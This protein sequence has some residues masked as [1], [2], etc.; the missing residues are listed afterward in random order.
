M[1][2]GSA[3][4]AHS[5]ASLPLL[6]R[7]TGLFRQLRFRREQIARLR[8]GRPPEC[9]R[10]ASPLLDLG[11]TLPHRP[12][13]QP[14]RNDPARAASQIFSDPRSQ[15]NNT[16][17]E[18]LN[19]Q[20]EGQGEGV[21]WINPG[22]V[23]RF[24]HCTQRPF[25]KSVIDGN[26]QADTDRLTTSSCT[27]EASASPRPKALHLRRS[28]CQQLDPG[29]NRAWPR[30][31]RIG[32]TQRYQVAVGCVVKANKESLRCSSRGCRS[33]GSRRN[34]WDPKPRTPLCSQ[35]NE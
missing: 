19:I 2:S 4:L 7:F 26:F 27:K 23:S 12:A 14:P 1:G 11:S 34:Y 13:S 16:D 17:I 21:E 32:R 8:R 5:C 3:R 10:S 24:S 33:L 18:C 28:G 31:S 22:P 25:S 29:A 6:Y 20:H 15:L 30:R 9:V 35:N